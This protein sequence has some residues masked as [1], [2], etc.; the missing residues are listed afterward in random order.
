[1]KKK[2]RRKSRSVTSREPIAS[3][4][5]VDASETPARNAPTSGPIPTA[6]PA[7]ATE[8]PQAIAN[9][10][11]RSGL[12]ASECRSGV[13]TQRMSAASTARSAAPWSA[14]VAT[15]APSERDSSPAVATPII[16]ATTIRSCTIRIPTARRPCSWS[17]SWRSERSLT[18][19][20][21]LENASP[22]PT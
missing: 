15:A 4:Y 21:V 14:T 20:T 18:T 17:I 11:R 5:G 1:M 9:R 13:S 12:R 7:A 6:S 8:I 22:M 3:R 2:S 16:A 19:M 10:S